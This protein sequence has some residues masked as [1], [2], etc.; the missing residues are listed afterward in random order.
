MQQHGTPPDQCQTGFIAL[1]PTGDL[2][3]YILAAIGQAR[4]L[5][6]DFGK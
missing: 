2:S 1:Q 5:A 3:Q 6:A 4:Q